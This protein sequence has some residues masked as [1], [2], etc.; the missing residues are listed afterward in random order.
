MDGE[1]TMSSGG[2]SRPVGLRRPCSSLPSTEG[3]ELQPIKVPEEVQ[4]PERVLGLRPRRGQLRPP[5]R[6]HPS[7]I[8]KG[9]RFLCN[10]RQ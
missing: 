1:Q 7:G 6:G 9:G 10:R 2:A 8:P 4:F 3:A 5:R